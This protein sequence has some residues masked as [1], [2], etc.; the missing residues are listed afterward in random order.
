MHFYLDDLSSDRRELEIPNY[1]LEWRT[2]W[3]KIFKNPGMRKATETDGIGPFLG[4]HANGVGMA[5]VTAAL[6][7]KLFCFPSDCLIQRSPVFVRLGT[8]NRQESAGRGCDVT[9]VWS[10]GAEFSSVIFMCVGPGSALWPSGDGRD[11]GSLLGNASAPS[12]ANQICEQQEKAAKTLKETSSFEGRLW[13]KSTCLRPNEAPFSLC[14]Q[15]GWVPA[16]ALRGFE[17]W[18]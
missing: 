4:S 13:W 18:G 11:S 12:C 9:E 10:L 15:G 8:D 16:A 1:S 3:R 14:R 2:S 17:H 7:V 5:V 6:W